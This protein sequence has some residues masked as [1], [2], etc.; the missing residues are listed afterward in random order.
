MAVIG[1]LGLNGEIRRVFHLERR[2]EEIKR[3]G[4]RQ[5][6]VPPAMKNS[7]FQNCKLQVINVD[8]LVRALEFI[9]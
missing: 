5:C 2:I 9:K 8:T 7:K 1:E 6:L 4:L 3:L